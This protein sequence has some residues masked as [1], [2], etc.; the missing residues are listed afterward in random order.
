MVTPEKTGVSLSSALNARTVGLGSETIVLAHGFG[1]DQS[2]WDDVVPLLAQHFSLVLFDWP[3]SGAVKDRTLYEPS[4]YESF[5]P[6]ADDLIALMAEMELKDV[7][8]AGHSM[9]AMIG[10]IA[11]VKKPTVFKSLILI[12]ASPRYLLLLLLLSLSLAQRQFQIVQLLKFYAKS[13]DGVSVCMG[14]QSIY[15]V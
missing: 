4:K 10:C 3:F 11:S 15:V 5:E 12:C 8:F 2:I 14:L 1:T 6:F 9:S 13:S 7:A